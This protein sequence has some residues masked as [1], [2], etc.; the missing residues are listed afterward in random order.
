LPN[1]TLLTPKN[2]VP[3]S[4]TVVPTGP[5][6]GVKLAKVGGGT[7]VKGVAV[8]V[9]PAEFVTAIGPVV[10]P[11]GTYAMIDHGLSTMTAVLGVP[12]NDTSV[13]PVKFHPLIF[14]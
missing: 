2:P 14:V 5:L 8:V 4:V 12:L 9:V 1:F 11:E 10:A 7:I 3:V 13:T 6:V